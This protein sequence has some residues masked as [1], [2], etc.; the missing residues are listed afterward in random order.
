MSTKSLLERRKPV[1]E[2]T[3]WISGV[4]MPEG[5]I[6]YTVE[7]DGEDDEQFAAGILERAA[8]VL[9]DKNHGD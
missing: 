5:M 4:R 8:E 1:F 7:I 2:I 9:R 3:A 6:H